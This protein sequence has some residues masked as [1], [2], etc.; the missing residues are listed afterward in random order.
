MDTPTL[1]TGQPVAPAFDFTEVVKGLTPAEKARAT[2]DAGFAQ[3]LVDRHA[4][5]SR[6]S[7]AG[8]N[9]LDPDTPGDRGLWEWQ[10]R[11]AGKPGL[12][13]TA[14]EA[15][16]TLAN[17]VGNAL[18]EVGS[19]VGDA[20]VGDLT[21][22]AQRT[23]DLATVSTA[24]ALAFNSAIVRGAGQLAEKVVASGAAGAPTF[25]GSLTL[26]QPKL[27][28]IMQEAAADSDGRAKIEETY[29]AHAYENARANFRDEKTAEE[30]HKRVAT[31]VPA[32]AG[33]LGNTE[34]NQSAASALSQI[35]Q[36]GAEAII[37]K[38]AAVA[39]YGV[40]SAQLRSGVEALAAKRAELSVARTSLDAAVKSGQADAIRDALVWSKSAAEDIAAREAK[41][42]ELSLKAQSEVSAMT[43]AATSRVAAGQAAQGAGA[44]ISKA[45]NLAEALEQLPADLAAKIAPESEVA[46]KNLE[47]G[48]RV[49]ATSAVGAGVGAAFDSEGTG[50]V[51][52]ALAGGK[53]FGKMGARAVVNVGRDLTR[54]GELFA[55]G[56][57]TLP[58]WQNVR[59]ARDISGF[60]RQVGAF[61]D[62]SVFSAG[63]RLV[64]G[65][66]KGGAS[67][68]AFGAGLGVLTSPDDP[69][70]GAAA[71]AGGAAIFGSTVGAFGQWRTYDN[72]AQ[73]AR[74]RAG[75]LR[76]YKDLL[77]ARPDELKHFEK[78]TPFTQ[79]QFSNYFAAHPDLKVRY[80][81]DP[82]A[83]PG[84]YDRALPDYITVNIRSKDP[85]ADIVGHEIS[86]YVENHELGGA[87]VRQAIGDAEA[88]IPGDYTLRDADGVPV[89]TADG[90]SFETNAEFNARRDAYV[91]RIRATAE[92]AGWSPG[93]T[94]AAV[95]RVSAPDYIAREIFAEQHL[96]YLNSPEYARDLKGIPA[97]SDWVRNSA[98]LK[99]ALAKFGVVFKGDGEMVRSGILGD[100]SKSATFDGLM[101]E[102]YRTRARAKA[103]DTEF[104]GGNVIHD[105]KLLTKE[106][107]YVERYYDASGEI[108]RD[109]AGKPIYDANGRAQ[110]RAAAAADKDARGAAEAAVKQLDQAAGISPDAKPTDPDLKIDGNAGSPEVVQRRTNVDGRTVYA[111]RFLSPETL[112][113]I[114]ASGKLNAVQLDNLRQLNAELQAG[115]GAEW[116]HFYQ[117][118]TK[119]GGG[120]RARSLAGR[121]RTDLVYGIQIT[122]PG[123]I[124]IQS[125]SL[126]VL[127][128]NAARAVAK[129]EAKLWNNS[130]GDLMG[131]VRKYLVNATSGLPGDQGLGIEKK[132][133]INNLLGLRVKAHGDVNPLFDI[134][135]QPKTIITSLRLDRINRLTPVAERNVP[136]S[137]ETYQ[138]VVRNLRPDSVNTPADSATFTSDEL[139]RQV[140]TPEFKK[141]FGDWE[142]PA[143][144]TSRAKGPVSAVMERP[145]SSRQKDDMARRVF[146]LSDFEKLG[147][148]Q[149]KD[150]LAKL[151]NSGVKEPRPLVVFHATT[152]TFDAFESGRPTFDDMGFFGNVETNRH[153]IFFSDSPEQAASYVTDSKG[154]V[155]QGARTIPAYLDMK[156][157]MQFDANTNFETLAEETGINYRWLRSH[158]NTWEMFD[159]PGGKEF[160]DGLKKAGYD[161]AIFEEDAIRPGVKTGKTYAV[162]DPTQ[163]KSA[164]GNR[165][166]FD[167][168]DPDIR[169]RPDAEGVTMFHG[170]DAEFD[171]FDPAKSGSNT[172]D[173][174]LGNGIYFTADRSAAQAYGK[175]VVE[176]EVKLSNPFRF[177]EG[178]NPIKFVSE[179]GGA[180]KF[181]AWVKENGHDGVISDRILK[182][183][184]VFDPKDVSIRRPEGSGDAVNT[185]PGSPDAGKPG[186]VV[187]ETEPHVMPGDQD[188][189]ETIA[190]AYE[191]LRPDGNAE[192]AGKPILKDRGPLV[193]EDGQLAFA[194][195]RFRRPIKLTHFTRT[196]GLEVVDP[197][198]MGSGGGK[199]GLAHF[200]M[201][202]GENKSFYFVG[203]SKPKAEENV[204]TAFQFKHTIPAFDASK[205]YDMNADPAELWGDKYPN[206]AKSEAALKAAGYD[207][208]FAE[209]DE[210]RVFA[211]LFYPLNLKTGKFVTRNPGDNV[212]NFGY[213]PSAGLPTESAAS[214]AAKKDRGS[215]N[216]RYGSLGDRVS[217]NPDDVKPAPAMIFVSPNTGELDY[218]TAKKRL[219]SEEHKAFG[220]LARKEVGDEAYVES[221]IGDWADGAED[222]YAISFNRPK[223]FD[224]TR[225]I[226]AKLG[227]AGQQKGVLHVV[228]DPN[229]PDTLN[230]VTFPEGVSL[231]RARKAMISSGLEFRTIAPRDRRV[232]AYIFDEGK[233]LVPQMLDLI[234]HVTKPEIKTTFA[235][236][237]MF[238]SWTDRAEG[239]AKFRALIDSKK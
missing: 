43:E 127:G 65:A 49:A 229:G 42:A 235:R 104:T 97:A 197:K 55:M 175:R 151:P 227:I 98:F 219:S 101:R 84:N 147:P 213:D 96:A 105:E 177:P 169:H 138:R 145:P 107:G 70:T 228:A 196:E 75:Q 192:W 220:D 31:V 183:T 202:K 133:F 200:T 114:E 121:W 59:K 206:K 115:F 188:S 46:Q 166:T 152:Q 157:P 47:A 144:F 119:K 217:G 44:S 16:L 189:S 7:A 95:A 182:Q 19:I 214:V 48:I 193:D 60:T 218:A 61:M 222:T 208:F 34:V 33:I 185:P 199:V 233:K 223:T 9:P 163:I 211:A 89:K 149:K 134:T 116:T 13:K 29:S 191:Q 72:P 215:V 79:E 225:M 21:K 23:T 86:H 126:E 52:G 4:D 174:W 10:N 170:T 172:G 156:S 203:N 66:A 58:F 187:S 68:A 24:K 110:V 224:E 94:E 64:G 221:A 125:V 51:V 76:I 74:E 69:V 91:Q 231:D 17:D 123:N 53:G 57:A 239:V 212:G 11:V 230:K 131:D 2:N 176:A 162:F 18:G 92:R 106:T 168:G 210:G 28:K 99:N 1:T 136:F 135:N 109:T 143:A 77:A 41:L 82:N 216:T 158:R 113:A 12:L 153:A 205:L 181:T 83:A 71:G 129:G 173:G 102:Y 146:G 62:N 130:L 85:L 120:P 93:Q 232:V 139:N 103:G 190:R 117:A 26:A 122:N 128:E 73:L 88:G 56:E 54:V 141:W 78:L 20:A 36:M 142:D 90:K 195:A 207:G 167:P 234:A 204:S 6:R 179:H 186:E 194:Q 63:S 155:E 8:E 237:E 178:V 22:A 25:W 161:G 32:L 132:N 45:G 171:N 154:R 5:Y 30:M 80:V 160:V 3:T 148:N 226:A 40:A 184:V 137:T 209:T 124:L 87:I 238:G 81:D 15:A 111:G 165:G 150:V 164:T 50:A 38:G 108:L 14:G 100:F 140:K 112:A 201:M 236:G 37:A 198:F 180:E 67:A 35:P 118:A 159:G 27:A 39:G